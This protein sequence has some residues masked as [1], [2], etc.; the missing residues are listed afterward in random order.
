[1]SDDGVTTTDQQAGQQQE[2]QPHPSWNSTL[3]MF[4]DGPQREA[5]LSQIRESDTNSQKA[6]ETARSNAAPEDWRGLIDAASEAGLTPD[7]L[8]QAYN[9]L[10]EMRESIA[11]DPD[12][13]LTGMHAEI[14]R[15]VAAGQLT[16]AAG[17]AAHREANAAANEDDTVDLDTPE[18]QRL[19]KLQERLDAQEQRWEQEEQ[20]RQQA[21]QE[22]FDRENQADTER[23]TQEFVQTFDG[24]F[25]AD[26]VLKQVEPETRFIVANHAINLMASNP[27]LTAEK[28]TS[29]AINQFRTH[30]GLGGGV[31]PAT[32]GVPIGGGTNQQ[33]TTP[34]AG[35]GTA[36]GIDKT[37]EQAMLEMAAQLQQQ[38]IS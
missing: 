23:Q 10:D 12:A 6:I 28:A 27:D 18:Q 29:E 26:P 9:Q 33:I 21:E 34:Q 2:W 35:A 17:A 4:P 37:R 14:D 22:Q 30:F 36:R 11:A 25:E 20:R 1:M 32:P 24:A 5:L 15:A 31:K 16:R 8:G 13:W 19:A 3:E 7:E 38:G